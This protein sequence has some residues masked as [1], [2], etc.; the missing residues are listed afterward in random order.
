MCERGE[1]V[2]WER[3][4]G[5]WSQRWEGGDKYIYN[6]IW[7]ITCLLSWLFIAIVGTVTEICY[8]MSASP[9]PSGPEIPTIV[10]A[11]VLPLTGSEMS[12]L[13]GWEMSILAGSWS[14]PSLMEAAKMGHPSL[15]CVHFLNSQIVFCK[16]CIF[17]CSF[18]LLY[19]IDGCLT[20]YWLP[21]SGS[22]GSTKKDK[23]TWLCML[24][25]F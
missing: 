25:C 11:A 5:S 3:R 15:H 24:Q 14:T 10:S 4:Y 6:Y 13:A 2:M 22:V 1:T 17:L 20:T 16:Q 7:Y 23:E 8:W 19:L 12:A 9:L 18:L 21:L